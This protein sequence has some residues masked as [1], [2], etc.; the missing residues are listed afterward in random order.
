MSSEGLNTETMAWLPGDPMIGRSVAQYEIIERLGEGG[1]GV[2]YRAADTKLKRTVAL[3]FLRP[4]V[5]D[6]GAEAERFLNEAQ[7]AAALDHPNICTVYEIAED[8]GRTFLA[9]GYIGGQSLRAKMRAGALP[10]R[11]SVDIAI[12][13]A[14]GLEEAHRHGIVHRDIKPSNLLLAET[15]TLKIVDF[16]LAQL[17]GRSRITQEGFTVGTPSYMSPEQARGEPLDARTD[18]WALGVILYEM[19]A[20]EPPFRGDN[21]PAILYSIVHAT[22][23]PLS[24]VPDGVRRVVERLLAKTRAERYA[25]AAELL[26]DLRAVRQETGLT[27][28]RQDA[29]IR[30]APSIAVLPFANLTR[31]EENEYFSDGLTEE[32]IHMLSHVEE[33]R[34]VSRTSA[35]EFKGKAQDIRAI[36][37][38]LNV[39]TVL[40]GAVR[41][42]GARVRVTTQLINVADGYQI[43]SERYDREM[44]DI[45]AIQDE[46][47]KSIVDRLK[48]KLAGDSNAALPRRQTGSIEAY[49]LYLK[50]RYYWNKQTEEGFRKAIELFEQVLREEPGYAPAYCGLSDCYAYLGFWSGSPPVEI[51]PRAR[52]AVLQAV[53]LNEDLAD[54]HVSLGYIL[55]FFDWKWHEAEREFQR[56]IE[57]SPGDAKAHYSYSVCLTQAGRFDEA[58]A[59][60]RRAQALDPLNLVIN[61]GVGFVYYYCRRYERAIEEHRK[62]LELDAAYFE[63][64]AA[65]GLAWQEL[66]RFDE[67]IASF[68]TAR[69][70][71]QDSPLILACLGCC[72]GAAGRRDE[73]LALVDQLLGISQ[74]RYVAPLSFALIYLGLGDVEAALDWLERAVEARDAYLRY[75]QVSPVYD[76]LRS[77]PRFIRLLGV[78]SFEP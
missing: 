62:T 25:D 54:A 13:I 35:F 46:I 15:G 66:K 14:Q 59:E 76:S 63:V 4:G 61:T 77:H 7:A 72:L 78:M 19:I 41:R 28:T 50:G 1:M 17:P 44:E 8:S 49:H 39:S 74:T 16:G 68:E 47:A 52:E 42:A 57:L 43:W 45:F 67:A 33:L 65:I 9:M 5:L 21:A 36:G 58:L 38:K 53:A 51:W 56:A 32:L 3:K 48:G 40:E 2:V 10:W 71:S 20:G 69:R 26:G 11:D 31:D 70:L 30:R 55:L 73:A 6:E 60:I 64:H 34:V 22:P 24:Q 75:L 12:Q 29:F 27:S 23:P 37:T 18:L